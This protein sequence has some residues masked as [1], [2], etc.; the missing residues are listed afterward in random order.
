[1]S[2]ILFA[3]F[4]DA[5]YIYVFLKREESPFSIVGFV[6]VTT[7]RVATLRFGFV[8]DARATTRRDGALI[9]LVVVCF[10]VRAT[11]RRGADNCSVRTTAFMGLVVGDV[12][13]DGLSVVRI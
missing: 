1:M 7:V 5:R 10:A 9:V 13:S 6:R 2:A 3:A 12:V 11:T 8:T 4:S